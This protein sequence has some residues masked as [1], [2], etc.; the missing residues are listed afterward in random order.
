M[1]QNTKLPSSF[2]PQQFPDFLGMPRWQFDR[3]VDTGL[4]P[5]PDR[6]GGRWSR[7]TVEEVAGRLEQVREAVGTVPDMGAIR[8]AE[9]LADRLGVDVQPDAVH[10]LA[11]QGR[12][13]T[14]GHYKG[15][16]LYDGRDL[17]A[18]EAL[19]LET[20]REAGRLGH[21]LLRAAV[22]DRLN[23]RETDVRHLERA[24]YLTPVR[25]TL[26]PW[27]RRSDAPTVPLY[28][29]G[30][31]LALEGRE[32]IDWESVRAATQP[33][34]RSPFATLPNAAPLASAQHSA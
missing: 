12:V 7:A 19:Q 13:R 26:S 28:R 6:A 23:I 16:P 33:G 25:H 22:A 11:R 18:A 34:C 15:H 32:D 29:L 3:A 24:G 9:H 14:V 10:E 30:D 27:Q 21:Q 2:G 4:I 5:G 1:E 17:E 31:V 20:V 8:A